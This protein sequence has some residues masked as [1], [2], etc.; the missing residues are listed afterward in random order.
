MLHEEAAFMERKRQYARKK[1]RHF[2]FMTLVELGDDR[3]HGKR[4][5]GGDFES[6]VR[7]KLRDAKVGW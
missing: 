3:C 6:L 2:Y 7:S 1:G 4:W 5:R